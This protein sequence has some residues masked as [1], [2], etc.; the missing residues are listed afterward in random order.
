MTDDMPTTVDR[1]TVHRWWPP[2]TRFQIVSASLLALLVLLIALFDW[3]WFKR[4]IERLVQANTGR[5]FHIDGD[6]HVDLGRITLVRADGLRFAN[7]DWATDTPWMAQARR[8]ELSIEVWPLLRGQLRMPQLRLQQ[9]MLL[10]QSA[11]KGRQGGN[12]TFDRTPTSGERRWRLEQL[13]IDNGRMRFADRPQRTDIVLQL[14][15]RASQ[16]AHAAPPVGIE[17]SGRWRGNR[18]T[19]SGTAESPLALARTDAPYRIDLRASAGSTHARARGTLTNPFQFQQ[20]DVQLALQG[21]DLE[22]LYPLLGLAMPPTAPYA[23][24]GRLQRAGDTWR[25]TGFDGKVGNS[26]L[27]GDVHVDVSHERPDF[28]ARLLSKRLDMNDLSG[29]VGTAPDEIDPTPTRFL[30]DTPYDLAKLRAMDADVTWKA[31]RVEAPP[32]PLDDMDA[33][34]ILDDGLLRLEP[35]NFGVAG[36]DVRSTIRMNARKPRIETVADIS[37]H[38]VELSRLMPSAQLAE[39]AFGRIGGDIDI[40][41]HGNSI[42]AIFGSADGDIALGMGRG[43]ISNLVMELAGIDIAEAL[44]FLVT[45]DRDVPVRC[46]FAD[47]EVKDG[48]MKSR[49]LA[50]DTEDTI[51]VGEG[52]VSL[53]D[54]TLDLLLKPRPKDRSLLTL[55]SPLRVSGTFVDPSFRPDFA[56]LGLRGAVAI[57]LGSIAPPAALLATI[58]TGPGEDSGCGGEYAK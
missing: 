37:L 38:G 55:R 4:P 29:F 8:L 27:S 57:A 40:R 14:A 23:V 52:H 41:G 5:E 16:E 33:H 35:L 11:P 47:F 2:S 50:F 22:H 44:R 15:S 28:H 10:L 43:S 49:A 56:A 12:W 36:G 1:R 26:D 30:P 18:F 13:W 45:G 32:L 34:L 54:E 39:Q 20:F 31:Q 58:E 25:Y 9:P 3:N 19:L 48:R 21:Q 46:A 7:A 17:G 24:D 42:A 53:K 51:I 6:L